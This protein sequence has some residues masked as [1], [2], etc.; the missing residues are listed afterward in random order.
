MELSDEAMGMIVILNE[1]KGQNKKNKGLHSYRC[2]DCGFF[3]VGHKITWNH[4][5][6][7]N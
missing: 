1:A 7:R 4:Y 6:K 3:H 2:P 5:A